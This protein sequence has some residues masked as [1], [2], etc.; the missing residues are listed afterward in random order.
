MARRVFITVG[1]ASGDQH[2]GH[3]IR[4]LRALDPGI[5]IEGLG[6]DEMRAA[7]AVVHR[8]TVER[9][10]MGWRAVFRYVELR[11][12]LSWTSRYFQTSP[13]NLQICIDSWA[14]NWHW[15]KLA[16]DQGIPV[17]YYVAPQV[18]A[19]RQ[20]RIKKLKKYID[21]IACILPF[22]E[23]FFGDHGVEATFVGH[24]LFDAL[25]RQRM[26][27]QADHFPNRPPVIGLAPGSRSRVASENFPNLLDVA[28]QILEAFPLAT[29][30]IPT[31]HSTHDVVERHLR[32][33]KARTSS[34]AP[35]AP[36]GDCAAPSD[37]VQTIGP[38]SF[39]MNRFDE[40]IAHCDL[41][42]AVS[43]TNNLHI[44]GHGVPLIVVYRLNPV[45][46]NLAGQ[47]IVKTRTFSLVNLLNDSHEKIVPEYIPWYGSNA[48]VAAKA[49][50]YL[51]NPQLLANQRERLHHL[52]RGINKPGAS[53][54]AA[55]LAMDMMTSREKTLFGPIGS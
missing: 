28:D 15:A 43:G 50:E 19:S 27:D 6:G 17:L 42:V 34:Q 7:G 1:E 35:S 13:P 8:D 51:R 4:E 36:P 22:E 52:I 26:E 29:F 33:W 5:I 14:M 2:A 20:G 9:A 37:G 10:A 41:C 32:S 47:F 23:K 18:W 25:P 24:P 31:M 3:L 44:A 21:R 53:R 40:L 30:M 45:I 11:R 16:H 55:N 48:P 38:F 49:I 39:G 12:M 54:N 46:W